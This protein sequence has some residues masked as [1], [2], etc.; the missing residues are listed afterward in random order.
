LDSPF[1][2]LGLIS[3]SPGRPGAFRFKFPGSNLIPETALCFA[4]LEYAGRVLGGA[5]VISLS[6]LVMDQ[7]GPGR[8]FKVNQDEIQVAIESCFGTKDERVQIVSA[9]GALMLTL[10]E[11]P[12]ELAQSLLID[13]HAARGIRKRN[14]KDTSFAGVSSYFPT[15]D[16]SE[17]LGLLT[18]AGEDQ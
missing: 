14:R 15:S 7:G 3:S 16:F 9:A 6:R 11:D 8:V 1:R 17:E 13:H 4:A 18:Y 5:K 2:A 10:S 12:I